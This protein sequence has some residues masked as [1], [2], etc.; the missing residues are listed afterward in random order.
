MT[1]EREAKPCDADVLVAA[2]FWHEKTMAMNTE[3]IR[4]P[5]NCLLDELTWTAMLLAIHQSLEPTR[6]NHFS[7]P[8][9]LLLVKQVVMFQHL[10]QGRS[11]RQQWQDPQTNLS[12]LSCE[13]CW[14]R[15]AASMA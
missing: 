6:Q 2:K 1:K 12:S 9:L 3:V 10:H 8:H 11:D 4:C 5:E 14:R 7:P 15:E 13:I